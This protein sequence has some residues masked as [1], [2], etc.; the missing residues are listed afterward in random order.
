MLLAF[1]ERTS[2]AEHC[3]LLV[4]RIV[5]VLTW[6]LHTAADNARLS[7]RMESPDSP[8]DTRL[9]ESQQST[10]QSKPMSLAYI[11]VQTH[12]GRHKCTASCCCDRPGTIAG[13]MIYQAVGMCGYCGWGTRSE[14]KNRYHCSD[15]RGYVVARSLGKLL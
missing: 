1:A 6:L 14:Q 11:V 12:H 9:S 5:F 3:K 7:S 2:M 15:L 10:R 8:V 13:S 4:T